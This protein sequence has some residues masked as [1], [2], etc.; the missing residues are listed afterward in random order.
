MKLN[1][2]LTPFI[3]FIKKTPQ[4]KFK[5]IL[6]AS[7]LLL[8][9]AKNYYYSL[10]LSQDNPLVR[11]TN[12]QI[13]STSQYPVNTA[14]VPAPLLSARSIAVIDVN[15]KTILFQKNPN[16]KLLPASTT[17]IMT[18]M[19]ALD[20]YNLDDIV[21]INQATPAGQIMGL[22]IGERITVANL[23][24]GALV[25]SGNDA[26]LALAS[27]H[28]DGHDGFIKA[29]NRQALNF[30]LYDTQFLNAT[31][32]DSFGHY[33]TVHDL[34]VLAS[35]AMKNDTFKKIVSVDKVTVF[36]VDNTIEHELETINQL[37]G[38]VSGLSGIKTG[39]TELAG[40]CLV[41]YTK[42]G[43]KEIITVVLGSQDRFGESEV[44]I[45]WAFTNH[46]WQDLPATH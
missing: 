8:I 29:M 31:G 45:D 21:V 25:Q 13:L 1:Q 34:S 9:P 15:S 4:L 2:K 18:A 38:K 10:D 11:P 17:K 24:Y 3:D 35:E 28:P 46:Q 19:V 42:R 40:E 43:G 39:W 20:Q 33:T 30:N 37:L 32:L 23:L 36:D 27:F 22:E 5:L 26:A 6:A 14:N 44:L 41:T 12:H 16:E 7:I